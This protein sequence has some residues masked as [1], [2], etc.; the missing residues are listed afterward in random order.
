[1]T[2]AAGARLFERHDAA[3]M[4]AD[5][6]VRVEPRA[7]AGDDHV[8]LV[9]HH[10]TDGW[11][12]I[13]KERRDEGEFELAR[14]S[15]VGVGAIG[16]EI[17]GHRTIEVG[18]R[19]D[20]VLRLRVQP[21]VDVGG[22][23]LNLGLVADGRSVD[24]HSGRRRART[25]RCGAEEEH[26]AAGERAR[27]FV[28]SHG[29]TLAPRIFFDT[30]PRY[31]SPMDPLAQTVVRFLVNGLAVLIVASFLPGMKVDR[32]RDAVLFSVVVAFFNALAW[33]LFGLFTVPFTVITLGVGALIVNGVVFVLADKVVKGVT[34]SGWIVATIAAVLVSAVNGALSSLLAR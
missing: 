34:I 24:R 28:A 31:H 10:R 25:P 12:L 16:R 19:V 29:R 17:V 21:G 1:M 9:V 23:E 20:G 22:S 3:L 15:P 2:G 7:V 26:P 6:R 11:D 32:F 8:E 13:E 14:G 30:R 33:T 5:R 4:R 27:R 18:C